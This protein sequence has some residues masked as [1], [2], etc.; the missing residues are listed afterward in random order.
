VADESMT[1]RDIEGQAACPVCQAHEGMRVVETCPQYRLLHCDPC[2]L[3]FSDPMKS[4]QT[5]WYD[6][7]YFIRH[8]AVDDRLM[9]Y[10]SWALRRLPAN[11]KVLDVACGTGSF[12]FYA[13]NRGVD[14]HGIDFST[15]AIEAGKQRFALTT[16]FPLSLDE[17][18]RRHP[19]QR[20]DAVTLFEVLEHIE[21]PIAFLK[22]VQQVLRPGGYI[23]FSV[24]NRDR[25]PIRDFGDYPPNHLTRWTPRA[26]HRLME[27]A[28]LDVVELQLTPV[29]MS[30]N[31]FF[32]YFMRVLLY[33]VV[34]RCR[35]GLLAEGPIGMREANAWRQWIGKRLS[36]LRRLRDA[37]MWVP[38]ILFFPVLFGF[39]DG[40]NV[41]GMVRKKS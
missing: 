21:S 1:S 24:P 26:M 22:E 2:D 20:F 36:Q 34:S 29:S 6:K 8:L 10:F 18:R 27:M 33:R 12:V 23:L 16:L 39:F 15:E 31:L 41:I 25:W 13:R 40:Y 4:G 35:R 28:G 7:S 3:V 38:T 5:D 32:G 14:A 9:W 11:A 17:Y 19:D 30:M 37:C